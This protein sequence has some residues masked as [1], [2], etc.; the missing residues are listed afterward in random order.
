M[1]DACTAPLDN[2]PEGA[3]DAAYDCALDTA[4]D[5]A[6]DCASDTAF[7]A[8]P[9]RALDAACAAPHGLLADLAV[10]ALIDEA[11]LTPKP[12]L[13]DARGNGAHDDL[14]LA[15]ML[16]SARALHPTFAQF[17]RVSAAATPSQGLRETLAALGRAGEGTMLAASGGSNTHRG[18]IWIVGLLVAGAAV[19]GWN[20]TAAAL[21]PAFAT[22]LCAVAA[23]IA[24]FPDRFAPATA[25]HGARARQRFGVGGARA[26]A[27]AGFPHVLDA[28]LPA[29]R[30]AR[31]RG[32]AESCARLDALVTIMRTLDDTCL[33]HRGGWRALH[34]AQAGAA[35]VLDAGGTG[36]RDGRR[37]LLALHDTLIA[38]N[39]SPG[40][41][42]DL[43]AATLFIDR[44][45]LCAPLNEEAGP[46]N[47]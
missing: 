33:L 2:A 21:P 46:W 30:A 40:G 22:D 32:V 47:I 15:C 10:G 44:L 37:L 6:C 8:A 43:L 11:C 39:A 1:F 14:D 16:R 17:A 24:R 7:D 35:A 13:V 31:R 26:Q 23:R 38:L 3:L 36:T 5:A 29:L 42:A 27:C 19:L 18:A 12:A 4:L 25:S 20:A 9:H 34:A 45:A 28:G 41:A